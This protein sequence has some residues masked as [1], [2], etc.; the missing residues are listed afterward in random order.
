MWWEALPNKIFYWNWIVP[1]KK[2][3]KN[4]FQKNKRIE[5][6][7]MIH[8]LRMKYLQ[9]SGLIGKKNRIY[10]YKYCFFQT[11]SKIISQE[12]E[13]LENPKKHLI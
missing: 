5:F 13:S 1:N 6:T 11:Q 8:F 7:K 4:K 2:H 10:G 12:L 3:L 9:S